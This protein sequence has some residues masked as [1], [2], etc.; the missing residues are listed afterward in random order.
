MTKIVINNK[1][2]TPKITPEMGQ[3][4]LHDTLQE[5]Y[6]IVRVGSK[7]YLINITNGNR[8]SDYGSPYAE[9][10]FDDIDDSFTHLPQITITY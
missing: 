2:I 10:I 5:I 3:Y 9:D 4:W 6:Q 7:F 1:T 8:W